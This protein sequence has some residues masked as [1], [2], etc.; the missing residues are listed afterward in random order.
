M[1]PIDRARESVLVVGAT[2][3]IGHLVVEEAARKGHAAEL[4]SAMPEKHAGSSLIPKWS[5]A[6]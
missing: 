6:S 5:L 3:S 1:A 4:S 2:G